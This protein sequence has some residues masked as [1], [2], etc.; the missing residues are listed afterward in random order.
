MITPLPNTVYCNRGVLR[1]HRRVIMP[2]ADPTRSALMILPIRS[3]DECF[4]A[5]PTPNHQGSA[6]TQPSDLTAYAEQR[7]IGVSLLLVRSCWEDM[8]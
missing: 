2:G 3:N 4:G 7:R 1:I 6:N 8:T 5:A